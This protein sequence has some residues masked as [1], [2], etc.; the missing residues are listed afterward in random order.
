MKRKKIWLMT[1]APFTER[2]FGKCW[3]IVTVFIR[4]VA[5]QWVFRAIFRITLNMY[6]YWKLTIPFL[7]RYLVPKPSCFIIKKY[8]Y[9]NVLDNVPKIIISNNC[10][11]VP[12]IH[13]YEILLYIKSMQDSLLYSLFILM[14]RSKG[15]EFYVDSNKIGYRTLPRVMIEWAE[16][17]KYTWNFRLK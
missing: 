8:Y 11:G 5:M 10:I 13:Y 3:V 9:L 14:W 12:S 7:Y 17:F 16:S 1:M 15:K 2:Q 4:T 6:I